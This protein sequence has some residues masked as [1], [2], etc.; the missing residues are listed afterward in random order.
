MIYKGYYTLTV[1]EYCQLEENPTAILWIKYP[2]PDKYLYKAIN[3]LNRK[4]AL[5]INKKE[6]KSLMYDKTMITHLEA[7]INL[8]IL[9][10]KSFV[11]RRMVEPK[12]IILELFEKH[13]KH[14]FEP[15]NIGEIADKI[16]KLKILLKQLTDRFS[17]PVQDQK[18][19]TV[20]HVMRIED[21]LGYP[22]GREKLFKL[23]GYHDL[24][25]KKLPKNQNNGRN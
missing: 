25:M 24:A 4:M 16:Q 6:S 2:W 5:K 17:Q 9:L 19:S 13:F 12:P 8:Y 10:H 1:D 3:N 23:K 11:I 15:K 20:E 14:K 18:I 7:K 22:I 21:L